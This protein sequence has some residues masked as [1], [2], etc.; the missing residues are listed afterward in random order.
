MAVDFSLSNHQLPR[1]FNI[2]VQKALIAKEVDKQ[3]LFDNW[4]IPNFSLIPDMG[5]Q[6]YHI[7]GTSARAKLVP[8]NVA[9]RFDDFLNLEKAAPIQLRELA[10][11]LR[12]FSAA[13]KTLNYYLIS[14]EDNIETKTLEDISVDCRLCAE[15]CQTLVNNFFV[16]FDTFA[17]KIKRLV[18]SQ[19]YHLWEMD[20]MR[21]RESMKKL[22]AAIN[23]HLPST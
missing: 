11:Q 12:I 4:T 7:A 3:E 5:R 21:E 9:Q 20:A 22:T 17:G 1:I 15:R 13:S 2:Y 6:S 16:G 19:G 8:S 23:L 14:P 10:I 18:S